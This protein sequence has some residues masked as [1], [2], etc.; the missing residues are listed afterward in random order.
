MKNVNVSRTGKLLIM[1]LS[2]PVLMGVGSGEDAGAKLHLGLPNAGSYRTKTSGV[3]GSGSANANQT[4]G[5]FAFGVKDGAA[6][7]A[8][9]EMSVNLTYPTPGGSGTWSANLA[10]PSAG[11]SV[12]ASHWA[13]VEDDAGKH[14]WSDSHTVY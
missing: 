7:V 2:I 10:P 4:A 6:Y 12:G 1:L 9:N 3:G 5:S 14:S 13:W 8:E 11:W